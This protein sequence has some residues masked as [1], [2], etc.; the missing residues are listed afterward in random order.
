[1]AVPIVTATRTTVRSETMVRANPDA[2]IVFFPLIFSSG[3]PLIPYAKWWSLLD[4][5]VHLGDRGADGGNG[6]DHGDDR[7]EGECET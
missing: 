1:M 6:H 7:D 5:D 4:D 3:F 2:D